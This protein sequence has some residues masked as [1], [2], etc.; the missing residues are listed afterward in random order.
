[1]LSIERVDQFARLLQI[2]VRELKDIAE[3]T[4][5]YC[6]ELQLTDSKPRTVLSVRG[7][8]RR[9]QN[10]LY[11]NVLLPKIDILPYSHGGIAGRS[12]KTNVQRHCNSRYVLTTDISNFYPTISHNRIFQLFREQFL[13][14]DAVSRLCTKFCTYKY[15]LP[16]GFVTSPILADQAFRVVDKRLAAA[17]KMVGL[18]YTRFVDDIAISGPFDLEKSGFKNLVDRIVTDHGF[19][20]NPKKVKSGRVSKRITITGLEIHNGHPDVRQEF[21]R[22]LERQLTDAASLS[23]G[24][25]FEG[26]YYTSDQIRGRL[27]FVRWINPVRARQLIKKFQAIDWDNVAKVAQDRGFVVQKKKL[28]PT[29][30]LGN[31][32]H[33]ETHTPS[34]SESVG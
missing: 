22:E 2:P 33:G 7:D 15:H 12:I 26:P 32:S 29:M 23:V 4:D 25:P 3:S 30:R 14:S 19:S 27:N 31:N 28:I 5:K 13:C 20:L 18:V 11:K 17:C 6:K 34:H 10:K 21:A 16:L 1:M 9:I 8:L 24:G